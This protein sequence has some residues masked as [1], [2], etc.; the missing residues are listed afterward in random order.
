[1]QGS[2]RRVSHK[3]R[4]T[5]TRKSP[6]ETEKRTKKTPSLSI[7]YS[8]TASFPLRLVLY[9]NKRNLTRARSRE[10]KVYTANR[11][12]QPAQVLRKPPSF[13]AGERCLVKPGCKHHGMLLYWVKSC[14]SSLC[15]P[16]DICNCPANTCSNNCHLLIRDSIKNEH[17]P[18]P[19]KECRSAILSYFLWHVRWWIW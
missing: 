11:S 5:H 2:L 12:K 15:A 14:H 4:D 9:P 7:P 19:A 16:P 3:E 6:A 1:M 10:K 8:L 17:K 13:I 18:S